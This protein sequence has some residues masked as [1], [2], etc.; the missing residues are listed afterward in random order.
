MSSIAAYLLVLPGAN[1]VPPIAAKLHELPLT[2]MRWEDF[3]RLC[4][5][6]VQTRFG[7]DQCEQYGV[8]G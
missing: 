2:Q 8:P 4:L 1:T 5:R 3:K 6:L 7:L